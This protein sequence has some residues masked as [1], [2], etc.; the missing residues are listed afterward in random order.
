MAGKHRH[1]WRRWASNGRT[2]LRG[3]IVYERCSGCD[4]E[5]RRKATPEEVAQRQEEERA[6]RKLHRLAFELDRKMKKSVG[7]AAMQAFERFAKSHPKE[8]FAVRVDD[9]VFANSDIGFVL[10]ANENE[11]W[12]ITGIYMPQCGSGSINEHGDVS[13]RYFHLYPGHLENLYETIVRLRRIA[14]KYPEW[15]ADVRRRQRWKRHR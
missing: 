10:N 15:R 13:P 2:S 12:C 14:M 1:R 9:A 5:K 6:S 11:L 7:Y 3:M 4:E 8:A